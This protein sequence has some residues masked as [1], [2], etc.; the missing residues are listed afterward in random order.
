MHFRE[1]SYLCGMKKNPHAVALGRASRR[2]LT[3]AQRSESARHA[4]QARW[5]G[6]AMGPLLAD[7]IEKQLTDA[8]IDRATGGAA[9]VLT[10][11]DLRSMVEERVARMTAAEKAKL[12]EHLLA[13]MPPDVRADLLKKK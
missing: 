2:K 8:A 10:D 13:E 11:D 1:R 4:V 12:L 3:A 7:E 5:K 9:T 6:K